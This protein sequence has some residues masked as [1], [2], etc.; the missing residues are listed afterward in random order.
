MV[1][2]EKVDIGNVAHEIELI[3]FIVD[4]RLHCHASGRKIDIFKYRHLFS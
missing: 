3:L 4:G 2:Q 1:I